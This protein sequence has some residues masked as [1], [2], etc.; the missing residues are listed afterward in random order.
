MARRPPGGVAVLLRGTGDIDCYEQALREQG[1]R[2]VA[3]AGAFWARQEVADL[4]AHL[5]ALADP[6]DEVALYGALSYPPVGPVERRDGSAG[7]G[8]AGARC[9][10]WEMAHGSSRQRR[11]WSCADTRRRWRS[12][13]EARS[14]V[15]RRGA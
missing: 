12:T 5:R 13:R 2:T 14:L 8:R 7:A 3:S 9:G 6:R 15:A 10:V 11:S 1:L 4:L